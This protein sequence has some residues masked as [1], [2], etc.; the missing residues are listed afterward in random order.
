MATYAEINEVGLLV[1]ICAN[2]PETRD[3]TNPIVELACMPDMSEMHPEGHPTAIPLKYDETT[4][5]AVLC[6]ETWAKWQEQDRKSTVLA[7][8]RQ[9]NEMIQ[10]QEDYGLDYTEELAEVESQLQELT[11]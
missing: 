6:E 8:L 9:K 5:R 3:T 10:A 2:K 11:S 1:N 4:K 7:L